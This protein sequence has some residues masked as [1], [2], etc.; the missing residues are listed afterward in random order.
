MRDDVPVGPTPAFVLMRVSLAGG[1]AVAAPVRRG[2]AA[3]RAAVAALVFAEFRR[4]A[5]A[6]LARTWS[7]AACWAPVSVVHYGRLIGRGNLLARAA[8]RGP[9]TDGPH[10]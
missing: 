9:S 4:P 8:A 1:V 6:S 3:V 2:G 10:C 5:T 7:D